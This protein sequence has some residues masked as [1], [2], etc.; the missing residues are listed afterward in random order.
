MGQRMEA[1]QQLL[2][3]AQ[4]ETG[5]HDFGDDSFRE[6]LERLVASLQS[7]ASLTEV[8]EQGMRG[9]V[10]HLLGQRLQLEDWYRRHPEIDDE[11]IEAPL[12][13]LGLPRTGSTALAF[14]LAEDPG[15]RSLRLFEGTAPCPP[16]STVV[17]P[18]P[19][20]ARAEAQSAMMDQLLP[21]M[22][23]L[24]PSTPTGPYEC[25]DLMGLD[26]KS[27]YFQ[28]Y[29]HVPSYSRWLVYEADL[30][31][32]YRYERRVLKL[33]QWGEPTRP[34]RLKCPNH[35]AHLDALDS[36]FPDARFVMTHRD[37]ADVIVSVA[38]VYA[39]VSRLFS[40]EP[41]LH[42]L[43]AMNVE[44]WSLAIERGIAFRDAGND[45][46]FYDMDFRAVQRDPIGEVRGLYAWLGEPVSEAFQ[47]GMERWW[48][49]NAE[50]RTPNIHPDPAAFGIDLA[51]VRPLF[52]EYVE[53]MARWTAH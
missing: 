50:T 42:Y 26:F 43:G 44:H 45:H 20:I 7:E 37:P 36:A 6:G 28:A 34:W 2:D 48:R 23:A 31:S 11:A 16:P 46:R 24:V 38:D 27:W 41:D 21:R 25:Q 5:L 10:V 4:A 22:A 19:R 1:P 30:R 13:G 12:I 29:A 39:E 17:G 52:A 32:T 53:R 14:L 18:D 40:K 9:L 35:L 15:A 3:A 47:A 8:G 49:Q 51:E 33:L